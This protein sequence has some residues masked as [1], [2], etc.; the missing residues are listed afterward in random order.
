MRGCSLYLLH[1]L[2]SGQADAPRPDQVSARG[3]RWPGIATP[4]TKAGMD[5]SGAGSVAGHV[6]RAVA[7][8]GSSNGAFCGEAANHIRVSFYSVGFA[9]GGG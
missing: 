6:Q 2:F 7:L 3:I 5:G 4:A 1:I 9:L 8:G